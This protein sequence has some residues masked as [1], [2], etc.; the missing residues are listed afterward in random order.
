MPFSKKWN[1]SIQQKRYLTQNKWGYI[2]YSY[3]DACRNIFNTIKTSGH[4]SLEKIY[5]SL[6]SKGLRKVLLWEVSWRLSRTATYWPPPTL[7]ATAVFLSRSP[8]LLN[9]GTGG[10]ASAWTCFSFQHL[11]SNWSELPVAGV[12]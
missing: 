9:R 6:N 5:L 3:I 7:L 12:I 1:I 10:P 8:E 2:T 11:L 4:S